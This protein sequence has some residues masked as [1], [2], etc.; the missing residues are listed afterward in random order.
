VDEVRQLSLE[1]IHEPVHLMRFVDRDRIEFWELKDSIRKYGVLKTIVVRP[2]VVRPRKYELIDGLQRYTASKDLGL[3]TIPARI[4]AGCDSEEDLLAIQLQLNAVNVPTRRCEYAQ[5]IA[6]LMKCRPDMTLFDV[7]RMVGKSPLWVEL[8]L[9][10]LCL[11]DDVQAMIRRGEICMA[12]ALALVKLPAR[13]RHNFIQ[14]ARTLSTA[15][16]RRLAADAKR[17]WEAKARDDRRQATFEPKPYLRD[18][19]E[20]LDETQFQFAGPTLVDQHSCATPLDGFYVG[21]AWAMHL[22][23]PSVEREQAKFE[24]KMQKRFRQKESHNEVA[25]N[26]PV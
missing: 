1:E 20:L 5:Q 10:L 24:L 22:D 26:A 6:K 8:T 11:D 23:I 15:S 14:D 18:L 9:G 7:S 17:E 21:L 13:I 25:E 2:S 12:N 19:V 4:M 3:P 16:F